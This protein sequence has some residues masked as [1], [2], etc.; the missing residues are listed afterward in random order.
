[1]TEPSI[2]DPSP[3]AAEPKPAPAAPVRPP[4]AGIVW[5]LAAVKLAL[6][7]ATNAFTAYGVHRDE[8]LYLAM[9]RHLQLWRMDFPPL[10]AVLAEAQRAALGDSLLSIRLAA[11]I[12]GTLLLVM[13]ALIA[14]ELGGGR[15][16]QG[17][18]AFAVLTAVLF[19]RSANLFQP[20]VFDQLW[21]TLALYALVRLVR[22]D[23]RR[24][25]LAIG[26]ICG[27]GL[28][29]KFSILFFGLALFVAVLLTR[30]RRDLA[31]PWPWL[32]GILAIAIGSP[33]LVGQVR[34]G[35]PF[36][37]SMEDLNRTQLA[38]VEYVSFLKE[39]ALMIGPAIVLAVAGAVSLLVGRSRRFRV[40]GWACVLAVALL[41]V[42]HGKAYYA[43]PVYP[44]LLGA[45]AVALEGIRIRFVGP[46]LRWSA[47][48]VM[49]LGGLYI[50]PLGIP[51][52]PPAT[53][54]AYSRAA[55]LEMANR[56]NRGEM[57]KLPQDYGDMLPWE[58]EVAQVARVYR[59][60]PPEQ[61]AR[62]VI[63]AGNYGQAA[64]IDL[65]GPKYGLPHAVSDA[66]TYWFYGP[67]RLPGEVLITIGV[68][69]EALRPVF[70]T[71]TRYGWL[72]NPS[73]TRDERDNTIYVA[74][75]PTTTLQAVWPKLAGKQ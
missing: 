50:L 51:I 36:F 9:G 47:V 39:Q 21:W 7:L 6:H 64:A 74:E 72:D 8:L 10:I 19:Q 38:H 34:L 73:W 15:F 11:A 30:R 41:M 25:W 66:G 65:Y 40:V 16:A 28:L 67:G 35:F 23:G 20:V 1:M 44:A 37:A 53:M 58:D 43:G 4:I 61:R 3:P 56:N 42:M 68:P 27:V 49:A 33:S 62:A 52:L 31:T 14:R 26:V 45:G 12:A 60:L 17:A 63:F 59:R 71:V 2:A 70:A 29:T 46:L 18:A 5:L 48:A 54:M 75:G 57:E 32:A 69:A 13:A 22:S 24:W 55:G